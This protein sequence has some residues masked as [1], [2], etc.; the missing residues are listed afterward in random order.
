MADSSPS[1]SR[2]DAASTDA[3]S[4]DATDVVSAT[5]VAASTGAVYSPAICIHHGGRCFVTTHE[6]AGMFL[7]RVQV[8]CDRGRSEL[9][10]LLHD[11]GVELLHVAAN[12]PLQIHDVRDRSLDGGHPARRSA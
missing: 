9:V 7:R 10:P 8:V 5:R 2:T 4:T 11:G 3:A 1:L 6:R 12:I